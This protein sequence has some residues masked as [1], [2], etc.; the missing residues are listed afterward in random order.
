MN[1]I[2]DFILRYDLI[3][4]KWDRQTF[5]AWLQWHCDHQ[6]LLKAIDFDGSIAGVL[7]IRTI[8]K[9][10][11]ADEPYGYDPEGNIAYVE[12]CISEK[13]EA[14]QA[15]VAAALKRFGQREWLAWKRPPYFVCHFR[16]TKKVLG[17]LLRRGVCD[18]AAR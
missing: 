16:Q 13:P 14:I 4:R 12:L 5:L 17:Q 2:A 6:L 18:A 8:M 9:A 1:E 3:Y 15:L 10:Q 7:V 11:E